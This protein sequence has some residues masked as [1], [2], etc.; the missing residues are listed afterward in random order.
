MQHE[1]YGLLFGKT[2]LEVGPS[3]TANMDF[4]AK[5]TRHGYELH[6][7]IRDHD[8][9]V[10]AAKDDSRLEVLP[11]R[12]FENTLPHAFVSDYIHWYDREK[13]I[14]I[15]RPRRNPWLPQKE[16]WQLK[17]TGSMWQLKKGADVLVNIFSKTAR[18]FHRIFQPLEANTHTHVT[19]NIES[20]TMDIILPRLLLEFYIRSQTTQI[21]SRQYRTM[22]VDFDQNICTL[23]G[24][25]SKLVLRNDQGDE[26][27]ILVPL[28]QVFD[29]ESV[30]YVRVPSS[31]HIDV[32]IAQGD[33][34]R[35]CAYTLDA[36]LGRIID[37]GDLQSKL[38]LAYLHALTSHCL[39]DPF[40]S[41]TGTESALTI[42][43]SASIRSFESLTRENIS[44]FALI[45][46]LTPGRTSHAEDMQQIHW[47]LN[48]PV[49]SQHPGFYILVK[50]I[51]EEAQRSMFFH[52]GCDKIEPKG[53]P[54]IKGHLQERDMI[55]GA[56]FRIDGYGAENFTEKKDAHYTSRETN[57]DPARG[58]RAH[59]AAS[60]ILRPSAALHQ[61]V[62]QL[63]G[64]LFEKHL[65]E[66]VV[67]S[68][69]S[70]SDLA[71]LRFDTKWLGD[72]SDILAEYWCSLHLFL[73]KAAKKASPFNIMLWLSTMAYSTTANMDAIEAIA[74]FYRLG[75]LAALKPPTASLAFRRYQGC[76]WVTKDIEFIIGRYKKPP[77]ECPEARIPRPEAEN[78]KKHNSRVGGQRR[79]NTT[80]ATKKFIAALLIQ[81]PCS[82]PATPAATDIGIY[83]NVA[84]AMLE[85]KELFKAWHDNMRFNDYLDRLSAIIARQAVVAVPKLQRVVTAP[86]HTSMTKKNV[87]Y[88]AMDRIFSSPAPIL[89]VATSKDTLFVADDDPLS[90]SMPLEPAIPLIQKSRS[91]SDSRTALKGLCRDLGLRAILKCEKDYVKTLRR[92]CEA[93]ESFEKT[94]KVLIAQLSS[95]TQKLLQDYQDACKV[96]FEALDCALAQAV[97][98]NSG[99]DTEIAFVI[100]HAPR[101][102]PSSWLTRLN[103]AYFE[104]LSDPWK[105]VIIEYARA[106]TQLHRAHRMVTLSEKPLELAQ[107][108]QYAGHTNWSPWEFPETLLLEAESGILVREVQE[109]IAKQ[110]RDPP[111]D[112]NAVCQLNMGEGKSSVIAPILAAALADTKRLVRIIIAKPQ[113]KQMLQ[114]LISKLGGLLNR[115]VYHLPFSRELR[116][117]TS[118]ARTIRSICHECMANGGVILTQPEHI[119]SF[120]LMAIETVLI[121]QQ[122]VASALLETQ[123]FLEA[124][125]RDIVD[126]S[127][128]NFSPHFELVYTMG[129]QQAIDFAPQRWMI[130]QQVLGL[131]AKFAPQVKASLPVSI[132]VQDSGEGVF[133][134]VRVLRSDAT[135]MLLGLVARHIVDYGLTGLS[136]RTFSRV[137][138]KSAVEAYITQQILTPDQITSVEG[139]KFWDESTKNAILL[140]RGLIACGILRF[141]LGSKRW[142]VNFGLD[143]NRTPNTLL[144]VPYRFKD[145]PNP[146]S[147]YSHP[148]V[149]ILLTLLSHYYGGLKDVQMFQ[150]FEHL[151]NSDQSAV[152]YS[153]WIGTAS[154]NLPAVF[155]TLSGINL[156]DRQHCIQEIFPHLRHSKACIDYFLSRLVFPKELRQFMS[157]L[158]ASGWD[159]G[160]AKTN[161]TTG[162]SGTKDTMH[163]LPLAVKHLDLPSQS[164]VNALVLAYLLD[165]SSVE[166]LPPRT[167]STDA[168]H[169]LA[170]STRIQPEVRVIL[171]CGAAILEQSNRQVVE[172]WLALSDPIQ[173]HAA[174]YFE[175]NQLTVLDRTG[176]IESLQTSPFAKQLDVC[177][178]YLDEAN[179][180]GTDLKLPR[181]YRACL[182]L[183][184]ALSKDKLIQGCMRMRQ[185]GKGQSVAFLVPEEIATKIYQLTSNDFDEPITV[186]DVLIWSIQET[187]TDLKKSMPLWAVQGH[188]FL[189]H[190][191]LSQVTTMTIEQAKEFLE[192]E[193][194]GIELR[195]SPS[196]QGN[197]LTARSK[198][199]DVDNPSIAEVITRCQ[200][201]GAMGNNSADLDEEQERELAPEQEEEREVERP[202]KME[203][204]KHDLHT[205]VSNLVKNGRITKSS[206]AF[207]PAFQALDTTSAGKLC[208][209]SQFPADVF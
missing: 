46:K 138:E 92:S 144:A 73:P 5:S 82:N 75:D 64:G 21:H 179:T 208:G 177:V 157:K 20:G 50:E 166:L 72:S 106:I 124:S 60:L 74:A 160:A 79:R 176:R 66:V 15:F 14:V 120:K 128:E 68:T 12:L 85:V 127:D 122:D 23:V 203:A 22:L 95:D 165:T 159:M 7:G 17:R 18:I 102:S 109:V 143:P 10:V 197:K 181:H 139:S 103:R 140:V 98:G 201:F 121:D 190:E 3:N 13:D 26:R 77:S 111:G 11:S 9:L 136:T 202:G 76:N 27:M 129:S 196:I 154:S 149:L 41:C 56:S 175:D 24:L 30:Q 189:S 168:E 164:H 188:R 180:R 48:L 172:S 125:T 155:R 83:I 44:L 58:Q 88:F 69:S 55:R 163:V 126:E 133:P 116:L 119:L 194:Q 65:K 182:T 130:I 2:V 146:R 112:E 114:V 49:S 191:H 115:R 63:K 87:R 173:I 186:R 43:R 151:S 37:R 199:W 45:A 153:E 8:M 89:N 183:G 96:H 104:N 148:D 110:M 6:F 167:T 184:N 93:L 161:P 61:I 59:I 38:L 78:V 204:S 94:S 145:G 52:P 53:L 47:D 113:S 141:T 152:Q 54:T 162:F 29:S 178:V 123:Q 132:D 4:S 100:Q 90:S 131:V 42:L 195:Y 206:K 118:E 39:P 142:R 80:Q 25:A 185:L 57:A 192:D 171:D 19:F 32:T 71:D 117:S 158:S 35:I 207:T 16:E 198:E 84:D 174:I 51:L 34:T 108:L 40:T 67:R 28:P 107:E 147:E 150:A 70:S 99:S 81:W 36:T 137:E 86:I 156:K 134:R 91:V 105:A 193:G 169:V 33:A 62:P 135:D 200:G 170:A 31:N 187:W 1:M 101:I 205:H 97:Q 209:L